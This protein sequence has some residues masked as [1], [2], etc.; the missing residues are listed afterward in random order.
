MAVSIK[1]GAVQAASAVSVGDGRR[2]TSTR[3][4]T[5]SGQRRAPARDP[6]RHNP[7]PWSS[8]GQRGFT[9]RTG[10]AFRTRP[11]VKAKDIAPLPQFNKISPQGSLPP[12]FP[13]ALSRGAK[14]GANL[15]TGSDRNLFIPAT[16]KAK[17]KGEVCNTINKKYEEFIPSLKNGEDLVNQVVEIS[18]EIDVLKSQIENE[19]QRDLR[20]AVTEFS[21][22]KQQLEKS[23]VLLSV[24][25]QLHEF[26]TAL[27]THQQ[28]LLEKNYTK[29][30]EHLNKAQHNLNLLKSRKGVELKMLQVLGTELI[31]QKEKLLYHLGEEWKQLAVWN[32][33]PSPAPTKGQILLKYILKPLV[34]EP[35]LDV[36]IELRANDAVLRF[37][38]VKSKCEHELPAKVYLKI[39]TVLEFLYQH[40]LPDIPLWVSVDRKEKQDINLAELLGGMIWEEL[41]EIIIKNCLVFSIPANSSQ[42]ELYEEVIKATDKF[43]EKLKEM[44]FL[45]NHSTDLL[46]Y[47]RN[48]NVHFAS[49]KCQDVIVTARN[50]MTSEIHNTVQISA[51]SRISIPKLP[52]LGLVSKVKVPVISNIVPRD[53]VTLGSGKQL[54]SRT[55]C[56]PTCRISQSVQTLMELAYQTLSEATSATPECAVQLFYTVRNMFH[57]FYDVVPTYHKETLQKLPQLAAI[58]H[59]NCMYIAH[60]LITL[61][62]QFQYRLP[63]P[64]CNGAA[65]FVDFVPSFR[66]LGTECFLAQLRTQRDE[67]LERLS[68]ARNL[69]SLEDAD[70]YS[71]ANKAVRQVIHQLKRLGKVWQDVLPVHIYCKALGTLLNTAITDI[72]NKI[73]MLEDITSE[74][75]DGLYALCRTILEEGPGIFQPLLE[76]SKNK[77][78]QEEIPIYV[79]K[80]LKFQELMMVLQANLQELLDRWTDGKGPFAAEFSPIEAKNLIRALFQNTE[81][82]AAA[83][84]EIK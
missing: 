51:D 36:E 62:H 65:T 61:G 60:H 76:E 80:W 72:V 73:T 32:L 47:A 38:A 79:P 3:A 39:T 22:L 16:L 71:A 9:G 11:R 30:A 25:T 41:S 40:L 49:K 56:L 52:S 7:S 68:T 15:H 24:L 29:S 28:A 18:M 34:V 27:E 50:L 66:R 83:L 46:K 19:V 53:M 44:Q 81:R 58:H 26:D 70:N 43:E 31:V 63:S 82:R 1:G 54:S 75:A 17:T 33:P 57:L 21:E 6:S 69:S 78:F 37:S 77:T 10:S 64:L 84:A 4:P 2:R 20:V 74:S 45:Q 59:N 48:V 42:L 12:S 13:P 14:E 55:M 23:T 8:T 35:S 67:L 5:A